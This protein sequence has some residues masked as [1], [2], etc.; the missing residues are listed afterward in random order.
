I[1]MPGGANEHWNAETG[2]V[3]LARARDQWPGHLW[4][5]PLPE[6]HWQYTQSIQMIHEIF[7]ADAMVPMTLE[8]IGRGM[9]HLS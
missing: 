7:G 5:N 1:A 4:I 8:G 2:A 3:W 6:R 9:R